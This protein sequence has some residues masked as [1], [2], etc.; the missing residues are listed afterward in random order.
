MRKPLPFC[1]IIWGVSDS[2]KDTVCKVINKH[3]TVHN[4]KWVSL[5][6]RTLETWLQ[7]PEYSLDDK[8]FRQSTQVRNTVT[9]ELEDR[10]YDDLIVGSIDG[11]EL[12]APGGWLTVGNII[13]LVLDHYLGHNIAFTDTRKPIELTA[14]KTH[15]EKHYKLVFIHVLGRGTQKSSDTWVTLKD[16]NFIEE[17]YT[18]N[19]PK[20]LTKEG[21]EIRVK[22]LLE[23]LNETY[24]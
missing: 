7:I 13:K 18:I 9:G 1:F 2:G 24:N 6:K 17:R 11:W 21:L 10:T 5:A 22:S 3:I 19:N 14:I 15:L 4:I 20:E 8:E 23:Y 16:F 12:I